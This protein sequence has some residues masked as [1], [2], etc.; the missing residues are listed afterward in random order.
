MG[1][2]VIIV[3]SSAGGETHILF[4]PGA[5]YTGMCAVLEVL[6][7]VLAVPI[8]DVIVLQAETHI[9]DRGISHVVIY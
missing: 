9:T 7:L 3:N 5:N 8:P 2:A 6:G 4:S 1:V